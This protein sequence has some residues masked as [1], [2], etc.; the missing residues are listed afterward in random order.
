MLGSP[1]LSALNEDKEHLAKTIDRCYNNPSSYQNQVG[2]NL[3]AKAKYLLQ[4]KDYQFKIDGGRVMTYHSGIIEEKDE[5]F[6]QL[7]KKIADM[8]IEDFSSN[9]LE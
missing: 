8:E 3:I 5:E 6:T 1:R 9:I 2:I 4:Q 7:L